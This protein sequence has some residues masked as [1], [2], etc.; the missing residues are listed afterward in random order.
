[1]GSLLGEQNTMG[2]FFSQEDL[3]EDQIQLNSS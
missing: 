3:R 2:I 1:M